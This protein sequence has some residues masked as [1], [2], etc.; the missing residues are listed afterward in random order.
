MNICPLRRSGTSR[1][2][3]L[4]FF[5]LQEEPPARFPKEGRQ[6]FER[7]SE[8][9]ARLAREAAEGGGSNRQGRREAPRGTMGYGEGARARP[10][11]DTVK[12]KRV[13]FYKRLG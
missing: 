10:E 11:D 2:V 3:F 5:H 13:L 9:R 12:N 6:V 8:R 7:V 1:V 4:F